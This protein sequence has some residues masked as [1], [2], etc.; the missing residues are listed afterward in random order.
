MTTPSSR[1]HHKWSRQTKL[2]ITILILGSAIYLL[3]K[4]SVAIPPLILAIII[5]FILSPLVGIMQRRLR[6]SRVTAILILYLLLF[7]LFAAVIWI[8]IPLLVDQVRILS[9]DLELFL[10]QLRQLSGRQVQVAGEV[11]DLGSITGQFGQTLRSLLQP[12]FNTTL[13]VIKS[14]LSS[15]VWIIFIVIISIYLIKDSDAINAWL[16]H[17]VSVEFQPDFIRLRNDLNTVWSSF[18]RG[19]ILLSFVV[20]GIITI[21]ALIIGLPMPLLMGIFAGL[22]EF[23]PSVGHGIWL[24][25]AGSLAIFLGST[26]LPIPPWAF[27]LV[28]LACHIIFTQFDLNYLIPRIIGR[29]VNLPPMVVILGIVAGAAVA[30]VLG[31][32]LAAPTIAS[33]RILLRYINARLTDEEPFTEDQPAPQLPPPDLGWWKK[34][35]PRPRKRSPRN[36][37]RGTRNAHGRD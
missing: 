6:L 13:D 3:Y 20:A 35:I 2:I 17:L 28:V 33:L 8:F 16:V 23:L 26:W 7:L 37:P 18:F 21:E 1:H 9:Q 24:V 15:L 25:T 14:I 27:L 36:Q 11:I 31:V 19:Q 29:S 32:V 12:A 34:E 22:M 5:A 10:M 30:G 4:F